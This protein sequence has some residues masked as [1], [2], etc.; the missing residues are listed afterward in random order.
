[1]PAGELAS[2]WRKLGFPHDQAAI[3][4]FRTLDPV[5]P[6]AR[7]RRGRGSAHESLENLIVAGSPVS[8][9]EARLYLTYRN[10]AVAPDVVMSN[11]FRP[12]SLPYRFVISN[13]QRIIVRSGMLLGKPDKKRAHS[14]EITDTGKL[15][16]PKHYVDSA[17][18]LTTDFLVVSRLPRD[19]SGGT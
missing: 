18:K 19:L 4:A 6:N 12:E 9:D 10:L 2:H 8:S 16:Q 5:I 7:E 3:A 11:V 13:E 1:L 17:Q 15:W 14:I